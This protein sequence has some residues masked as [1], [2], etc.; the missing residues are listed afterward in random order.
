MPTGRVAWAVRVPVSGPGRR[1]QSAAVCADRPGGGRAAPRRADRADR[2]GLGGDLGDQSRVIDAAGAGLSADGPGRG[3][4]RRPGGQHDH[5]GPRGARDRGS[6]RDDRGQQDPPH[7]SGA[8]GLRLCAPVGP[9]A[10]A[11]PPG[12]DGPPVR[13]GRRSEAPGVGGVAHRGHRRRPGDLGP[14][15]IG[16]CRAT[17]NS[18]AGC[19]WASRGDL[20]ARGLPLGAEFGG[21]AAAARVLQCERHVDHRQRWDLRSGELQRPVAAGPEGDDVGGRAASAGRPPARG[22]AGGGRREGTCAFRSRSGMSTTTPER[23]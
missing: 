21:P 16:P 15:G 3:G 1:G 23:P 12:V 13:V 14:D 19:A 11:A 2:W 18:S 10:S 8:D 17:G 7:P 5:R 9:G 4:A 22:Q 6:A 20:R